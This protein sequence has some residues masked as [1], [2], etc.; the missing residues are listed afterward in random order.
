MSSSFPTLLLALTARLVAAFVVDV[1]I[2]IVRA[3]V[4]PLSLSLSLSLRARVLSARSLLAFSMRRAPL[5]RSFSFQASSSSS[6]SIED[7][8]TFVAFFLLRLS[9]HDEKRERFKFFYSLQK[10][11]INLFLSRPLCVEREKKTKKDN[12]DKHKGDEDLFFCFCGSNKKK[13]EKTRRKKG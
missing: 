9:L 8:G 12:N 2:T 7:D 13:D 11:P 3:I 10:T 1:V 4:L 6:F 5:F